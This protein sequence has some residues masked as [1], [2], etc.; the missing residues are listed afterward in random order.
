MFRAMI[1][2][3]DKSIESHPWLPEVTVIKLFLEGNTVR[4]APLI[5]VTERDMI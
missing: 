3:I 4:K 5:Y 2:A 1:R